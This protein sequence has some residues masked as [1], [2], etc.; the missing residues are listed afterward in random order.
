M[1]DEYAVQKLRLSVYTLDD[2]SSHLTVVRLPGR[3]VV[4]SYSLSKRIVELCVGG[5]KN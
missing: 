5:A 4:L 3:V 2:L 1:Q